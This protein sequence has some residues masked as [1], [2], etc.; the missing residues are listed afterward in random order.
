MQFNIF[1]RLFVCVHALD[2]GSAARAVQ[3]VIGDK[4][5]NFT[6]VDRKLVFSGRYLAESLQVLI[7]PTQRAGLVR[8]TVP[9]FLKTLVS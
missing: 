4:L 7:L 3:Q 1:L 8:T 6:S 9:F 2:Q 5:P